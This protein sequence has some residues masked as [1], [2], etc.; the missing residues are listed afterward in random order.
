MR[1]LL[2][3]PP[4][5]YGGNIDDETA[6]VTDEESAA[7]HRLSDRSRNL[8]HRHQV[9]PHLEARTC[10]GSLSKTELG[11]NYFTKYIFILKLTWTS[12]SFGRSSILVMDVVAGMS[13][14][15]PVIFRSN[16]SRLFLYLLKLE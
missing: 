8:S 10:Q 6:R 12:Y 2:L 13:N 7:S 4:W 9:R 5:D 1:C 3:N 15:N 11:Q 14:D 16:K